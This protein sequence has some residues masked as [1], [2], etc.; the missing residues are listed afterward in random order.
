MV[1]FC[2]QQPT[3]R[4]YFSELWSQFYEEPSILY[5]DV[6]MDNIRYGPSK[7]SQDIFDNLAMKKR[8]TISFDTMLLECEARSKLAQKSGYLHVVGI[9]L[10]VWKACEQQERIFLETFEQRL[11][12]L[13]NALQHIS[14][15]HFSWFKLDKSGDIFN[16]NLIKINN[17]PN[18][19]IR[20][21]VSKRDPAEK[22]VNTKESVIVGSN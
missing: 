10:G 12:V 6:V 11:K 7:N 9:G 17:H 4:Y 21:F 3:K 1:L 16:E 20:V 5:K 2:N 8:Y 14:Y 13:G 18:D 15:V 22:L 19:G